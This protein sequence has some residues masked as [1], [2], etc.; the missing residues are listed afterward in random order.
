MRACVGGGCGAPLALEQLLR[1][2]HLGKGRHPDHRQVAA[3]LG[4]R[5]RDEL[6]DARVGARRGHYGV[7]GDRR[8][9][10]AL[11]EEAG[12]LRPAR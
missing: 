9:A 6:G 5:V 7:R 10:E 8:L 1:A 4:E 12:E 11:G 2:E 3:R